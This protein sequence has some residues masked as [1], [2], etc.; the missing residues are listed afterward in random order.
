MK[1]QFKLDPLHRVVLKKQLMLARINIVQ[2][3]SEPEIGLI[4]IETKEKFFGFVKIGCSQ[5]LVQEYPSVARSFR[6]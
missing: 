1:R 4:E 6:I 5:L 2:L 3:D